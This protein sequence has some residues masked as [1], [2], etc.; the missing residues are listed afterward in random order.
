MSGSEESRSHQCI[1]CSAH[2]PRVE[3]EYTLISSRFGWRLTRK[4]ENGRICLEWRCPGCWARFKQDKT[5][6]SSDEIPISTVRTA[7]EEEQP[8]SARRVATSR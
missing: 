3:T 7:R 2:A 4:N 8:P 1:D 6:T 5:L